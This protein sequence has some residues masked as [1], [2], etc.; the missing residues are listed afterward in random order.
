MRGKFVVR[1]LVVFSFFFAVSRSWCQTSQPYVIWNQPSPIDFP[2]PLTGLQYDLSVLSGPPVAVPLTPYYNITGITTSDYATYTGG[3]DN[4]GWAFSEEELG[5]SVHWSGVTFPLGPADALDAVS[6]ATV[7]LPTG[8]FG[9]LLL[10][11][12]LV[13]GETPSAAHFVVTYT[14]GSTASFD[15]NMSDWVIPMNCPG[16]SLAKCVA[17]RHLFTGTVDRNSTCI[18]GYRFALDPSRTVQSIALPQDRDA[19][20]MAMS[21]LPEAVPGTIAPSLPYGDVLSS[22]RYTLRATFTPTAPSAFAPVTVTAPLTVNPPVPLVVPTANWPAP[23]P[24]PI[25]NALGPG[26]LD[27]TASIADGAV[28]VPLAPY[29]RV[30]A[31]YQDGTQYLEKGFDGTRTAFSANQL[32]SSLRY[33]GST[34][35]LGPLAVPNAASSSTIALPVGRY[36]QLYLLGAAGTQAE[37]AQPFTVTYTDGTSTTAE[38]SLSSWQAPQHFAGETI[39]AQTTAG[40]LNDGTQVAGTF[41]VY[42][43]TVTLNPAKSVASLTLPANS[44]VVILAAGLGTGLSVRVAGTF[45][46]SPAAGFVPAASMELQT[47][48]A[49]ADNTDLTSA[50]GQ[51]YL[52]VGILDFTLTT[53]SGSV[54]TGKMGDSVAL[55][56]SVA[57]TG[58]AYAGN[59][60]FSV[61]GPLPPLTTVTFSPATVSAEAGPQT[62]VMTLH[63]QLLTSAGGS[64]PLGR[65]VGLGVAACGLWFFPLG[66]TRRRKALQRMVCLM[67]VLVVVPLG[68]GGGYKDVTYP[69]MLNATDGAT[70]HSVPITLHITSSNQ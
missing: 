65:A 40:N 60:T 24:I 38:V 62:V 68:C 52:Q 16:E 66:E 47:T 21:L 69:L 42:G 4:S 28:I 15:Q 43:Y 7:N 9:S 22:G 3:F 67:L 20:I 31:M 39:V 70:V 54:L 50:T 59:L 2:T 35:P 46:Y 27:A 32:G 12:D 58:I 49:P 30:N 37:V 18:Y 63:T 17:T 14:D 51:T 53:P 45:S 41:D 23:A 56:F 26:Q 36:A 33:A 19:V 6:G 57:P 44:D 1:W 61:S 34:F 5:S 10:L 25:G 8:N 29:Y 11:G 13:N 55:T 64:M 48:F